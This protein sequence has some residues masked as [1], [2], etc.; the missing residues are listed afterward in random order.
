MKNVSDMRRT[1]DAINF[2]SRKAP[3]ALSPYLRLAT[4][5]QN[6][7]NDKAEQEREL[8]EILSEAESL[9]N[10]FGSW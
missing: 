10:G 7:S 3:E 6:L 8:A 1:K 2:L 4:V 5:L 9:K